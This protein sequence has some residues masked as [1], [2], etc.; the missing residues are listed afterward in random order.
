M[1]LMKGIFKGLLPFDG[2]AQLGP[3]S[4]FNKNGD[5][6]ELEYF[7]MVVG[8]GCTVGH[9]VML[10]GCE[11]G[12]NTLIGMSATILNG[13]KIGE[14]C[15]IGAGALVT[16][17]KVIPDGSLV[18]GAPGKVVRELDDAA[19]QTL[20]ASALHYAN[21]AAMFREKLRLLK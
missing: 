8:K 19:I 4:F 7:P 16:A 10:H 6:V 2:Y 12:D 11:I 17:G 14:N 13:A 18:M 15:L 9:K 21:N 1:G 20:T 3:R 5:Y